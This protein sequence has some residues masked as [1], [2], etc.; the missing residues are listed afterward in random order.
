MVFEE[1]VMDILE[2]PNKYFI[3]HA[4][5]ADLDMSMGLARVLNNSYQLAEGL[6]RK[7]EACDYYDYDPTDTYENIG[8]EG[9]T[10]L[11]GRIFTLFVKVHSSDKVDLDTVE[12]CIRSLKDLV[13]T[14]GV[15]YLA[16]PTICCGNMGLKWRDVKHIIKSLFYDTDIEV[17]ICH[18]DA[19]DIV[20]SK[21]DILE[22]VSKRINNDFKD[23]ELKDLYDSIQGYIETL[24]SQNGGSNHCQM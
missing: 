11:F 5:S 16:F 13:E 15:K 1:K 8:L 21:E 7:I 9:D 2:V 18:T 17:L 24:E 12:D 19:K 22:L 14:E 10:L 6:K 23:E 20:P 4:S 3:V